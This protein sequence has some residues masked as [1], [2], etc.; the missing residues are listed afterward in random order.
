[1]NL[2]KISTGKMTT[3][4]A[5]VSDAQAH[6]EQRVCSPLQQISESVVC[7]GPVCEMSSVI[8]KLF[9]GPTEEERVPLF[10][11]DTQTIGNSGQ[12]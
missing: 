11:E 1:M 7:Q 6:L 3:M 2:W 10:P 4:K 8:S 5:F 9:I 12:G